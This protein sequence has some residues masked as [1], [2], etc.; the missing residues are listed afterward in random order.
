[1]GYI[2]YIPLN[3]RMSSSGRARPSY[4]LQNE[5]NALEI[6]K[7]NDAAIDFPQNIWYNK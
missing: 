5:K 1:M 4:R 2:L 3:F 6:F 7:Q